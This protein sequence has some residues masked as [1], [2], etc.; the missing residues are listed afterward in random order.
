[1]LSTEALHWIITDNICRLMT[2]RAAAI[3]LLFQQ[4][5]GK[6]LKLFEAFYDVNKFKITNFSV[7]NKYNPFN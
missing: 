4:T 3:L 6:T 5:S 1:M 2:T 7:N